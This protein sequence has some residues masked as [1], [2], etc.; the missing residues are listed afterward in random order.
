MRS[1]ANASF[2]KNHQ[3]FKC[4][5]SL[6]PMVVDGYYREAVSSFASSLERF[7][8]FFVRACFIEG[9]CPDDQFKSS[10]EAVSPQSERQ[11][12]A[13]IFTYLQSFKQTP[14]ILTRKEREFRN[15]VVH[16]GEIPTRQKTINFGQRVLEIIQP[17][18]WKIR[19]RFPKGIF[20]LT[21]EH[22]SKFYRDQAA[23]LNQPPR[24]VQFTTMTINLFQTEF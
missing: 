24:V 22:Q 2:C 11:L 14:D 5:L 18:I 15:E 12:G 13:Y 10:W 16:K 8:E 9:E 4:Y 23:K 21:T 1:Y 3:N 20:L 19:D 6:E 17:A 7:Y